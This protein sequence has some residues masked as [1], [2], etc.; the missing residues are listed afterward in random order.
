MSVSPAH[1]VQGQGVETP[2]QS[3]SQ[4]GSQSSG[5]TSSEG[6]GEE[7]GFDGEDEEEDEGLEGSDSSDSMIVSDSA[8]LSQTSTVTSE[9]SA[10]FTDPAA[11]SQ[12]TNASAQASQQ[13]QAPPGQQQPLANAQALQ[14]H[15]PD[16]GQQGQLPGSAVSNVQGPAPPLPQALPPDPP[17][18]LPPPASQD[19]NSHAGSDAGV[20]FPVGNQLLVLSDEDGDGDAEGDEHDVQAQAEQVVG[21]AHAADHDVQDGQE[22]AAEVL[23]DGESV[24]SQVSDEWIGAGNVLYRN[25]RRGRIYVWHPLMEQWLDNTQAYIPHF[26]SGPGATVVYHVSDSEADSDVVALEGPPSPQQAPIEQAEPAGEH[27]LA[28]DLASGSDTSTLTPLPSSDEES[29]SL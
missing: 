25:D 8:T 6:P 16:P 29:E 21:P 1:N 28:E 27:V 14:H 12:S 4:H 18:P 13:S 15:G 20:H 26:A 22:H 17:S 7:V 10:A 5:A 9:E 23:S 11:G 19:S 3:W 24:A 2:S